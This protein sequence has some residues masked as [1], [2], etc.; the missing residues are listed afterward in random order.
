MSEAV[1]TALEEA[2]LECKRAYRNGYS[3]WFRDVDPWLC[4]TLRRGRGATVE[5]D[6]SDLPRLLTA[7]NPFPALTELVTPSTEHMDRDERA[8]GVLQM[9]ADLRMLAE[10]DGCIAAAWALEA[11]DTLTRT[12]PATR[13]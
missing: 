3:L 1:R 7:L 4:V 12:T 9:L 6:T 10:R 8:A 5:L 2:G 13:P 11:L